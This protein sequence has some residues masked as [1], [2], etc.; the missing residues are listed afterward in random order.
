MPETHVRRR[1]AL[2]S[3]LRERDLD[4]L[5]VVDLR[6]VRYLTGFT[7]SNAALLV[8]AGDEPGDE[9]RTV[10]CTDGRYLTQSAQ[11]VPDLER[12][13]DRPC[14]PALVA[15]AAAGKGYGRTGYESHRVTVE[16]LRL[17]D[18]RGGRRRTGPRAG[19]RRAAADGQGRHR[20]RGAADGVRGRRPGARRPHRARRAR[21]RAH[22]ARGRPRPGEPDA[23]PRRGRPVVRDDR[24]RRRELRGPAPPA[25]RRRAARRATS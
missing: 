3:Q 7:G 13:I 25:D 21:R 24:G 11:Q 10:F 16:E 5:L 4:A 9:A 1:A 12:L 19:A 18:R 6:N 14:P 8:H 20:D 15:R 22:R 17:A 2:R 23:R